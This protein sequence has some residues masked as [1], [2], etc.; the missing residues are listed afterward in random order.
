MSAAI[1]PLIVLGAPVV[2]AWALLGPCPSA[3]FT[4]NCWDNTPNRWW[5][6]AAL[7]VRPPA[8]RIHSSNEGTS[9]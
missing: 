8:D 4:V 1:I 9:S 2:G 7:R 6:L 3:T 5:P